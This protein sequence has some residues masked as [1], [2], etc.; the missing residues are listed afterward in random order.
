MNISFDDAIPTK[1]HMALKKLIEDGYVRYIVSQ[2]IDGLHLRTGV[3]R[4]NIA[5][6]HG[7][8]FVE[9]CNA[10]SRYGEWCL[11]RTEINNMFLYRQFIR[12]TA[13]ATVGQ[14]EVGKNCPR[15]RINGRAC[16]GKLCDTVLDWEANL[17]ELDLEMGELHSRYLTRIFTGLLYRGD[18]NLLLNCFTRTVTAQ[19]SPNRN[20]YFTGF[21]FFLDRTRVSG[22]ERN[23]C[24]L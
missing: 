7:N 1:T 11:P 3:E 17:P 13:T 10:C 4:K 16:R 12:Y 15:Q 19:V 6:L 21:T 5:E 9:Q 2:N 22:I 23:T 18:E 20:F 8:M 14:K 24:P